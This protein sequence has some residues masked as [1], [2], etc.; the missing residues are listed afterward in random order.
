LPQGAVLSDYIEIWHK[1]RLYAASP[2]GGYADVIEWD[3]RRWQVAQVLEDYA[4][5][6]NGFCRAAC[7]LEPVA[8]ELAGAE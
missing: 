1:G 6:G 5:F 2:G 7:Q 4:H 3:G 8:R